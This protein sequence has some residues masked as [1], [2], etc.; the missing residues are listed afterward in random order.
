MDQ[1]TYSLRDSPFF[2][3]RSKAKLASLLYVSLDKLR[4]LTDGDQRY[5]E[6][7]KPKKSGGV[8]KIS[9]PIAPLKQVQSRIADLLSRVTP[10]NYL[11][12][13]VSG[14]SY[15]D[16]AAFHIGARSVRLLDIEDFFP[17]CTAKKAIWFFRTRMECSPDVAAI[18]ANIVTFRGALPQGSPCSPI[19]AYLCYVDMWNEISKLVED[20]QCKLS[21][22]ADDLTISGVSV[23]EAQ[24]WQIK[25]TLF[26]HGHRYVK[27]KERSIRDKPVEITG[28]I[29]RRSGIA[30]PNRQ[31]VKITKVRDEI[32]RTTSVTHKAMLERQ[33]RGRLAQIGQIAAA[34]QRK[35]T[36]SGTAS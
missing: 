5:F 2:R 24:I 6:F 25:K 18:L 27:N 19:L 1:R 3:L 9:A 11:F 34:D 28:V 10:P 4:T 12:A 22:Y 16:N 17:S 29:L 32:A 30:A 7:T 35:R 26:R 33:L 15:A 8:R 20:C 21:V 36:P 23:P 31:H 14:R 13:P